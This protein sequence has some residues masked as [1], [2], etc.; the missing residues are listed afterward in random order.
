SS[1]FLANIQSSDA[2]PSRVKQEAQVELAGGVAFVSDADLQKAL[3]EADVPRRA[4][5]DVLNAYQDARIDG[6]ESALA[7]L[8]LLAIV[9][10]LYASRIP[11]K[12]PGEEP[13]VAN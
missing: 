2:I 1:S 7:I 11:N 3:D 10:L 6:L 13:A 8:A 5:D 12:Q 9:A 4:T